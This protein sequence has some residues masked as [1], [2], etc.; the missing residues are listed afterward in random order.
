[1][2]LSKLNPNVWKLLYFITCTLRS[3]SICLPPSPTFIAPPLWIS[4]QLFHLHSPISSSFSPY[5]QSPPFSIFRYTSYTKS[6]YPYFCNAACKFSSDIKN[7]QVRSSYP[8]F[9]LLTHDLIKMARLQKK[10]KN[11]NIT[12]A[13]QLNPTL[14]LFGSIFILSSWSGVHL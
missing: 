7:N 6:I 9:I 11:A 10:I 4:L 14:I 2:G 1:M 12:F 8:I 5:Y 13:S 3:S